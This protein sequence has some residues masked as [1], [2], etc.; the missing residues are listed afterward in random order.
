MRLT[1]GQDLVGFGLADSFD[2]QQCLFGGECYGF[3]GVQTG[4]LE[5]LGI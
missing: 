4:I 2:R 5:F 1:F 3:D